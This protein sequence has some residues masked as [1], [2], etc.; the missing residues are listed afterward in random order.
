MPSMAAI[1]HI[2]GDPLKDKIAA[3]INSLNEH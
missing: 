3:A 2:T 1:L